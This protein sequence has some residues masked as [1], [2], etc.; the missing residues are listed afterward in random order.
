MKTLDSLQL[1]LHEA[2]KKHPKL[3]IHP[4]YPWHDPQFFQGVVAV[5]A[6]YIE[7]SNEVI[8]DT[9]PLVS[10]L[11]EYRFFAATRPNQ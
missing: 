1:K 6:D 9:D 3:K 7:H 4:G 8:T 5:V 10:W 11:D 2:L